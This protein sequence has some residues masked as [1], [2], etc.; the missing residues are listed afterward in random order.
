MKSFYSRDIDYRCLLYNGVAAKLLSLKL[1]TST[2]FRLHGRTIV[3]RYNI[4][5]DLCNHI[6]SAN[7][8][9]RFQAVEV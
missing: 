3:R 9:L 8:H 4:N 5:C 1:R 2:F 6:I 7:F